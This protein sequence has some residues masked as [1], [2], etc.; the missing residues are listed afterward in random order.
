MSVHSQRAT[1]DPVDA[2]GWRVTLDAAPDDAALAERFVAWLDASPAHEREMERVELA[3]ELARHLAA[4][5]EVAAAVARPARRRWPPLGLAA[6]A[7]LVA[8]IATAIAIASW[9][10]R[11][12]RQPEVQPELRAAAMAGFPAPPRSAVT[13]PTGVVVDGSSV[14]LLPFESGAN[15]ETL[16]MGFEADVAAALRGVPGLYVIAG[17]ATAPYTAAMDLSAADVGSQL[18]ARALVDARVLRAGPRVHITAALR[19]ARN[20]SVLWQSE[21]D[22]PLDRLAHTRDVIADGIALTLIG[23]GGQTARTLPSDAPVFAANAAEPA[24]HD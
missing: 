1:S 12:V 23:A 18:G 16:A 5:P 22:E 8:V 9:A 3:L 13:L 14:A 11:F 19:D 10:T 7:T 6:A 17:A 2:A 21:L 15:S 4:D 24:L 20:G